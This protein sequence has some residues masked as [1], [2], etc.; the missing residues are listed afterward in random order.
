MASVYA[1][2]VYAF[3]QR[4]D[5][6][7]AEKQLHNS[8]VKLEQERRMAKKAESNVANKEADTSNNLKVNQPKVD[9]TQY[10]YWRDLVVKLAS[11]SAADALKELKEKD[12]FGTLA[13]EQALLDQ[14]TIP[15]P[16]VSHNFARPTEPV[17]GTRL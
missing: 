3:F 9:T 14:E 4:E 17:Q 16:V 13:F 12:P 11:I 5:S 8:P 2:V 1:F 10:P 7:V 6:A 15:L